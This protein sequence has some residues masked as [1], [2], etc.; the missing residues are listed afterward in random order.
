MSRCIINW[1]MKIVKSGQLRSALQLFFSNK[2]KY[3]ILGVFKIEI[4]V[5]TKTIIMAKVWPMVAKV[6]FR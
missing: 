6:L 2:A 4:R 1:P 3:I 5:K